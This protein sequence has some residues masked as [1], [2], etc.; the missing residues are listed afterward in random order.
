ME[1]GRGDCDQE[2][3]GV[4]SGIV[5]PVRKLAPP[6][7]GGRPHGSSQD[8]RRLIQQGVQGW[9]RKTPSAATR[10]GYARDVGQF[11]DFHG[12]PRSDCEKLTSVLPAHVAAWRDHLRNQGAMNST[13]RRKL[14][15]LRSLFSYLQ[16]YGYAGAN[17][18]HGKFVKAPCVP[19]D[20]KTLG[21]SPSDCR[22]L[23]D[24][25]LPASPVGFRDRALLGVL[26]YS[27]CRVG[28]LVQL[29][30]GDFQTHGEHRVLRIYGKGGKERTVPLHLEAVERLTSW[31]AMADIAADR[32]GPL[33]RAMQTPRG[34]GRD[35]F[36]TEFLTT[37]AVE[38]L[39][40]R[41]VEALT[42]DPGV[43]V[44]SLRVTALTTARERG[45]DIIDLQDFAGHA[46]PRTTLTYI[47]ARDRLSK[48]PTYVLNY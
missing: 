20:G 11:L 41:Y 33:F 26:A 47:R 29:K 31:I 37:R 24:A 1:S 27:A 2:H 14:T 12:I 34:G 48:S 30:V 44:H 15:A 5:V 23:L 25:P 40:R 38:Q 8:V 17:P 4:P 32:S 19:R 10:D 22:R 16:I 36:R 3:R 7:F 35:G 39:M 43:T 6:A 9:L 13:V 45:A 28:E 46:D 42:L 21:L 18:A